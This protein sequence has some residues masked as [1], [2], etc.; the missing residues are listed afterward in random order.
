MLAKLS[1]MDLSKFSI[2]SQIGIQGLLYIR[3][4]V[5]S[6]LP[7]E[8]EDGQCF[9][10]EP[11]RSY[12]FVWA[13]VLGAYEIVRT[14]DQH[15]YRFCSQYHD[16]ISDMKK[17]LA[18]GRI[19]LAKQELAGENSLRNKSSTKFR[20]EALLTGADPQR[21]FCFSIKGVDYWSEELMDRFEMLMA[22]ISKDG[23][24]EPSE[25]PRR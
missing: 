6:R 20:A 3:T 16:D 13:W 5:T 17:A 18:Q 8:K 22:K 24:L 14:M 25:Q 9:V 4:E 1:E 2:F 21:G 23:I 11:S 10:P 7:Y 12:A 19:P 15:R